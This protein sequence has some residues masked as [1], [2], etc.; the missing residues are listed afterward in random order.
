MPGTVLGVVQHGRSF[1]WGR[2]THTKL[3]VSDGDMSCGTMT[4]GNGIRI[5]EE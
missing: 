1:E 4:T 5:A 3:K 2:Q